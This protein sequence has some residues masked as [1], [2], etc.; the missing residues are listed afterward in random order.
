MI[1]TA[2][3]RGQVMSGAANISKRPEAIAFLVVKYICRIMGYFCH[4]LFSDNTWFFNPGS[5]HSDIRNYVLVDFT[6][7][8]T[9]ISKTA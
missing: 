5:S 4:R 3:A 2:F 7:K 1:S 6:G 8:C 9:R